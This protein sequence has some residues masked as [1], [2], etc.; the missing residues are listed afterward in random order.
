MLHYKAVPSCN[1]LLYLCFSMPGSIGTGRSCWTSQGSSIGPAGT[2]GW[3]AGTSIKP[4]VSCRSKLLSTVDELPSCAFA[5]WREAWPAL[6]LGGRGG[7]LGGLP[8]GWI[9]SLSCTACPSAAASSRSIAL[10]SVRAC[11]S[12]LGRNS[13]ASSVSEHTTGPG[14]STGPCWKAADASACSTRKAWLST[15]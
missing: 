13:K 15:S 3:L 14:R 7:C 10:G 4:G 5:E 1:L 9:L 6:R 12:G 11:D 2:V 8:K